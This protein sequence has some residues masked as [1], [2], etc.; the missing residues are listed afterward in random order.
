MVGPEIQSDRTMKRGRPIR[1]K[2]VRE[3]LLP[4][5]RRFGIA[6]DYADKWETARRERAQQNRSIGRVPLRHAKHECVV[7]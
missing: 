5:Y 3:Q 4:Q 1:G 7:G 6:P 2:A